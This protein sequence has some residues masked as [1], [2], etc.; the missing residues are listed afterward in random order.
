V[1]KHAYVST[2]SG[3]FS[4]RS[5]GYLAMGR[6]V[7]LQDTGFSRSLPCG[8]GLLAFGN[9]DEALAAIRRIDEDYAAH[10]RAARRV[11]EEHFDAGACWLS[12]W[13]ELGG[14]RVNQTLKVESRNVESRNRNKESP[15][16]RELNVHIIFAA[17]SG[18]S[19]WAG[20]RGW[21]CST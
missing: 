14:R 17:A 10:C 2:K 1:A 9:P 3:W 13:N 20:T 5:C 4:D 21:T 19:L 15:S 11:A 16:W 7:V 12:C 18:G 8:E 6:P